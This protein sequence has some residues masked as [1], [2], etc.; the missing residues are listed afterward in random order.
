MNVLTLSRTNDPGDILQSVLETYVLGQQMECPEFC[1]DVILH[2][3]ETSDSKGLIFRNDVINQIYA[4][5][6]PGCALRKWIVDEFVWEHDAASEDP[7]ESGEFKDL[8]SGFLLD[9]VRE[10]GKRL[11][12]GYGERKVNI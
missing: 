4:S 11:E 10:Q 12:G 5:T 8:S 3:C 6:Q 2:A 9:A 7:L 1:Y